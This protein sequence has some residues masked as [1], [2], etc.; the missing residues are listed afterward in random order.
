MPP[1]S[2]LPPSGGG[3]PG[4]KT[5]RGKPAALPLADL[6]ER[7]LPASMPPPSTSPPSR[8]PPGLPKP[9][10]PPPSVP[11]PQ[12][13]LGGKHQCKWCA[14]R[15]VRGCREWSCASRSPFIPPYRC[16]KVFDSGGA[17]G[18]HRSGNK[19]CP[20]YSAHD[21]GSADGNVA[22]GTGSP[23][24]PMIP[25]PSVLQ[26]K[27]ASMPP[28]STSPPSRLPPG[29]PPPSLPPPSV[30]PPP[31]LLAISAGKMPVPPA[32]YLRPATAAARIGYED[33]QELGNFRL[34]PCGRERLPLSYAPHEAL[35]IEYARRVVDYESLRAF[36]TRDGR[37]WGLCCA[38]RLAR[39]AIVVEA[40]GRCLS[41]AEFA[42]LGNKYEHHEY[43]VSF[44][45]AM[46]ERKRAVGDDVLYIDARQQGNMMRLC[47]DS[48][49]PNLKLM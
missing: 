28:P 41:E 8:L 5:P 13:L 49:T 44:D 45:D 38:K 27:P 31:S 34:S 1:P 17:L 3:K 39:G 7:T 15:R 47:N 19:T 33:V 24:S 25:Q 21:I 40:V 46:L 20:G 14:E 42:Q 22:V 9:S 32:E 43:V 26:S 30:P 10:L 23:A 48:E 36:E 11:P 4:S 29:L 35:S 6:R 16:G 18:G 12:A 2:V 37:G